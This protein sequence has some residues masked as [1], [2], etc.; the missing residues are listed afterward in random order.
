MEGVNLIGGTSYFTKGV[1]MAYAYNAVIDNCIF[2][3]SSKANLNR[4]VEITELSTNL[5]ITNTNFNFFQYGFYCAINQEGVNFVN[6]YFVDVTV[7]I[8]FKSN[9]SP[10]STWLSIVGSHIDARGG[11]SIALD[12]ENT[13]AV[14]VSSSLFI[15]AGESTIRFKRVF[16]SAIVG[17]Q[18]YGPTTYGVRLDGAYIA[19]YSGDYGTWG[20]GTL[21]SQSVSIVGNNFRG[22]STHI[23][24]T[25]DTVQV[26]ANSTTRSDSNFSNSFSALSNTDSGTDNFIGDDIGFTGT[27]TP[28]GTS[29]SE[30]FNLDISKAALGKK[31]SGV[32]VEITSDDSVGATY[33]WG[34]GSSTKT[35]AVIRLFKYDG[36]NL[37]NT[38]YQYSV[39]VGP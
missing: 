31:P 8:L 32:S 21:P 19:P 28:S 10:R 1:T 25:S 30:E 3:G 37:S 5:T 14:F 38:A 17:S 20:G 9:I 11:T 2:S 4:G 27:F 29:P 23:S 15:A 6:C 22:A 33:N 18:I 36:T 7:G 13:S 24:A 16:E 39:R 12:V 35:N 26:Y 34:S